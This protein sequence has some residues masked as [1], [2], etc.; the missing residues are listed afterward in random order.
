MAE[1]IKKAK[2]SKDNLPAVSSSTGE[3]SIRYRIISEDKNRVSAWS[4]IFKVDPDYTYVPGKINV[5]ASTGAVSVSWD[6]VTI[7]IGNA[8]ISKAKEYDVWVKWSKDNA[9]GDWKYLE[10]IANTSITLPKPDT[11]YINGIDQVNI[12]NKIMIEVFLKGDPITRDSAILKVYNPAIQN[13]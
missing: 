7:K 6:A 5:A 4:Q 1:S 10:R 13:I 8:A 3:Y 9:N 11:F 2:I 12:P